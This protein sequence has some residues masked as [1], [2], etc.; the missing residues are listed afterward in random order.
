MKDQDRET[1]RSD[2]LL[3]NCSD[4]TRLLPQAARGGRFDLDRVHLLP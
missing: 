3:H 2:Q 4:M 1:S